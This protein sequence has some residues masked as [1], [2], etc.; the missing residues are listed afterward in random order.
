MIAEI[1]EIYLA[2]RKNFIG[3]VKKKKKKKNTGQG[4]VSGN[5]TWDFWKVS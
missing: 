3:N 1:H 4:D 5:V 2:R